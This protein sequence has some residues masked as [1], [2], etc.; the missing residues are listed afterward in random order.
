ML[1]HLNKNEPLCGTLLAAG[2][3]LDIVIWV[4][5]ATA[6]LEP[7]LVSRAALCLCASFPSDLKSCSSVPV[8]LAEGRVPTIAT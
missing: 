2:L 4:Y 8:R 1:R 5:K 6:R 3:D 7:S